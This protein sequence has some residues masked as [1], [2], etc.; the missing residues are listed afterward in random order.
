MGEIR[1]NEATTTNFRCT[2]DEYQFKSTSFKEELTSLSYSISHDLGAPLRAID[3][4]TK[5]LKERAA[6]ELD[7]VSLKYMDMIIENAH[8]MRNMIDGM[9]TYSN[10]S[11]KE[12]NPVYIDPAMVACSIYKELINSTTTKTDVEF[13]VGVIPHLRA[14][15]ELLELVLKN[16][17]GNAI[18]H[19]SIRSKPVIELG[20]E[21]HE[22]ETM[23]FVKDNGVGF[24]PEYSQKLFKLFQRL[25]SSDEFE[26][27]GVGL[28]VV[29]KIVSRHH[30][31]IWA[32]S[33]PG[34]GATFYVSIPKNHL[35]DEG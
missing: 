10:V 4:F 27:T 21:E 1:I 23:I 5:V 17:I 3:G 8:T 6:G 22:D 16:L 15:K 31:C 7:E 28:A 35:L 18:K 12:L 19:S 20:G 29:A 13:R 32:E 24:D 11:M 14:D 30:G 34:K 26:G 25:H 33:A 2:N 9:L